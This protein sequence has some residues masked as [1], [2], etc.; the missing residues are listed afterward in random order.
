MLLCS[1]LM[2]PSAMEREELIK[3]VLPSSSCVEN[4]HVS[5]VFKS[6]Y[7]VAYY[8]LQLC[9][10]SEKILIDDIRHCIISSVWRK[11]AKMN[12]FGSC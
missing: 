11:N 2:V 12:S 3:V 9:L 1:V 5:I 8:R 7:Q 10:Y 6:F 4:L